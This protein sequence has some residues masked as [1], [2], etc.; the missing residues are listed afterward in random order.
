MVLRQ[1]LAHHLLHLQPDGLGVELHPRFVGARQP[2]DQPLCLG[3]VQDVGPLE[4][5]DPGVRTHALQLLH[6][7][8]PVRLLSLLGEGRHARGAPLRVVF[9]ELRRVQSQA[10]RELARVSAFDDRADARDHRV[11]LRLQVPLLVDVDLAVGLLDIRG[12]A[13]ALREGGDGWVRGDHVRDVVARA[14]GVSRDLH[15]QC[16]LDVRLGLAVRVVLGVLGET[17]GDDELFELDAVVLEVFGRRSQE[18]V[19]LV[20]NLVD[21]LA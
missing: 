6:A 2:G 18:R 3:T 10:L 14:H 20:H 11:Q 13:R 15:L 7:R 21:G 17:L 9:V 19:D 12:V 1:A 8:E 16:H 5:A 4:L